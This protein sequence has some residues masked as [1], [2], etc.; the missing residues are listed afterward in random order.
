MKDALK[1]LEK[2]NYAIVGNHSAVQICR[3]TK[4]SLR[5]DDGC[6]K[7]KFYGISSA[8]CCQM[9]PAALWCEHQCLHC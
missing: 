8:G 4:N 9:T 3:W 2:M 1:L 7:E 5:G 6:W